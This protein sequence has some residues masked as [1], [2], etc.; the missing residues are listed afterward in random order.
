[1]TDLGTLSPFDNSLAWGINEAG[2]I[3][4]ASGYGSFYHAVL[5]SDSAVVDLNDLVPFDPYW[6][7]AVATAINERGQIIGYASNPIQEFHAF[8][9]TPVPEPHTLML[10]S[11]GAAALLGLRWRSQA[12]R[13]GENLR[14]SVGK[15][16]R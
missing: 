4:G 12:G 15:G 5:F 8:L 13:G 14:A 9:L 2:Q 16:G 7:L 10:L 3:V 6:T 1:M 11:C